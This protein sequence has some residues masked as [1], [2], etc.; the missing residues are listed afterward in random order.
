MKLSNSCYSEDLLP[1]VSTEVSVLDD[2]EDVCTQTESVSTSSRMKDQKKPMI[3]TV[4]TCKEDF[5]PPLKYQRQTS[6]L[7]RDKTLSTIKLLKEKHRENERLR[8]HSLNQHL[9][10][11]CKK[12]PGSAEDGKETKVVMMQRII[13][14]IAYLENTIKYLSSQLNIRPDPS[15]LLLTS[16]VKE[17]E[18]SGLWEFSVLS[19]DDSEDNERFTRN[20]SYHMTMSSPTINSTTELTSFEPQPHFRVILQDESQDSVV[21][22]TNLFTDIEE[23]FDPMFSQPES[24]HTIFEIPLHA[25]GICN[26]QYDTQSEPACLNDPPCNITHSIIVSPNQVLPQVRPQQLSLLNY[27]DD[28]ILGRNLLR[29]AQEDDELLTNYRSSKRKQLSPK[30][31]P[32]YDIGNWLELPND[33]Q[34][35]EL[36]CDLV[37]PLYDYIVY[38]VYPLYDYIVYPV[39]PLYDYIVYPVY[40]LYD[41]IVYPVYPL[42]DYIVY[43]VYPLYDYIVYPVYPLY[44]YIVYPVYPLYDYIVYPVYPLYDYIVYPVYPLYDYIVY[45]VYPLYDYIVYPVYPLYDY[46]VY[47]V[48]PLYDYIVYP[49]Y[50]LYDYIV[51]PVYPLYDY[52]EYPVSILE[53]ATE[54]S[55][56]LKDAN[57][58]TPINKLDLRKSS[59]MNGFMMYSRIHRKHFIKENPG[60]QAASISKLMGQRWRGMTAEQQ[61]PYREQARICSQELQRMLDES[62]HC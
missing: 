1:E 62:Y 31:V 54:S 24:D 41:Y 28:T 19:S 45:P 34:S 49:V 53:L 8:H 36:N 44:D 22:S 59:W 39:Y 6:F 25:E 43:P 33:C 3:H 47:P 17:I 52:I 26:C 60:L 37:Y 5:L 51:Y 7:T 10:L 18:K 46:I 12:V 9:R 4:T 23:K 35:H 29:K 42:Y 11:I 15:W 2:R 57:L 32:L 13:S 21:P 30:R 50:P 20:I 40:P 14:Y 38:P 58:E 16:N 56:V 55:K 61:T 48:Y 27:P